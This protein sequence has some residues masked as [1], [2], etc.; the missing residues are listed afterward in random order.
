MESTEYKK[1]YSKLRPFDLEAA[2]RGEEI[3]FVHRFI[4]DRKFIAEYNGKLIVADS[5]GIQISDIENNCYYMKP[6]AWVEGKPVYKGDVLYSTHSSNYKYIVSKGNEHYIHS[7]SN[8]TKANC[9]STSH[10]T[11]NKPK[12]KVKRKIWINVYPELEDADEHFIGSWYSSKKGADCG[13]SL[14]RIA[15]AETEI[16]YEV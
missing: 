4:E 8:E 6:L 7:E 9:E 1:D 2:N 14:N 3:C 12:Q 15:C 16:E 13:A 10:L 11:W 5:C